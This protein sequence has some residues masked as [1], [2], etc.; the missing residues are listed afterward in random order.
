MAWIGAAIGAVGGLLSNSMSSDK[1]GGAGSSSASK[2]P[3]AAAQ[4]WLLSNLAQGQALQSQYQAQPFSAQQQ[5]AYDNSY[6]LTDYGRAL[7]PSLLNQIQGQ[8]VGFDKSNPTAK[9]AAWDWNAVGGLGQ[10]SVTNAKPAA[11]TSSKSMGDDLSSFINQTE[12]L[13]G[14]NSIMTPGGYADTYG[15]M[16]SAYGS[17][18]GAGGYGSFRYGMATQPGTQARLDQE[19]YFLLGGADPNNYYGRGQTIPEFRGDS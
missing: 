11:D 14:T 10:T 6:A 15:G 18:Q 8:Q 13:N 12:G 9:P 4:P 19:K 17:A 5:A 1:N 7:V 3:W 16:Q 2:E